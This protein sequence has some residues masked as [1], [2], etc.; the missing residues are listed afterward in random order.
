MFLDLMNRYVGESGRRRDRMG[1]LRDYIIADI[2]H[3]K[4]EE[5][6]I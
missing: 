3:L 4:V 2:D 1:R 5:S 6:L